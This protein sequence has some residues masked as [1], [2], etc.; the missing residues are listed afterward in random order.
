[1]LSIGFSKDALDLS[2]E[3]WENVERF[4]AC[5]ERLRNRRKSEVAVAGPLVESKT[6]WKCAV[7]QQ[8]FLYR[9]TMLAS[10]CAE[11]WNS[12]NVVCSMLA[13][14]GLLE[15]VA[16]CQFISDE[17]R[18]LADARD[19]ETIDKLAN[20]QLFSTRDE[21]MIASGT[22]HRARSVL[23]FI[24]KLDKKLTGV[25]DAYDFSSEWCHPNGSGHLM[26]YGEIDRST[27]TVSFSEIAPRVRGSQVHVV[28]CFMM[29]LFVEPIMD[30]FDNLVPIVSEMDT[31]VGPWLGST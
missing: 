9:I 2:E 21:G 4:N 7:L 3:R 15:T 24:D 31:N 22:G 26:T 27:G 29:I 6:A 20:E 10:G 8:S 1:M 23:T 30:T 17:M 13:A 12:G 14:R 28:T 5:L 18:A 16:L 19:I 25:R 11:A